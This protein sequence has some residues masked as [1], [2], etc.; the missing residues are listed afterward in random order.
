MLLPLIWIGSGK[1]GFTPTDYVDISV[2]N[3]K[4]YRMANEENGLETRN[5]KVKDAAIDGDGTTNFGDAA[6]TFVFQS[7]DDRLY[8]EFRN[9]LDNDKIKSTLSEKNFY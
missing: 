7:A 4:W 1:V 3:V 8:R 5:V 9:R 2:D 6:E